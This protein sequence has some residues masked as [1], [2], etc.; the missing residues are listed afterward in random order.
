MA[1]DECAGS[2]VTCPGNSYCVAHTITGPTHGTPL[3][4]RTSPATQE[5]AAA[6]LAASVMSGDAVVPG[7]ALD[8][9]PLIVACAVMMDD[10]QV[11]G[12][13]CICW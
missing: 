10:T 12:M 13:R 2:V 11:H 7:G 8:V 4:K 9:T 5:V 1:L 6:A 3:P